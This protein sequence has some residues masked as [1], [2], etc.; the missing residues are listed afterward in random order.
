MP[1]TLIAPF[2]SVAT[3][4]LALATLLAPG[5]AAAQAASSGHVR[6]LDEVP[7]TL[8]SPEARATWARE[9]QGRTPP[10]LLGESQR[11]GLTPEQIRSALVPAS[12][13]GHLALA[14]AR[15]WPQQ[16]GKLVAIACVKDAAPR[17]DHGPDC[18]DLAGEGLRIYLGVLE[19][20]GDGAPRTI[21]RLGPLASGAVGTLPP[22]AWNGRAGTD[23]P[24]VMEADDGTAPATTDVA[25][26]IWERFD[27]A[28][29]RLGEGAP[30]FGLRG[31]WS[32]GYAGGGA[33][34]TALYLFELRDGALRAV[35]GAP[36]SMFKNLA[37]EWNDDGTRQHD[38]SE[39]ANIV[40]VREQ[41]HGGYPD[42]LVRGRD[43]GAGDTYRWSP[44]ARRYQL[45]R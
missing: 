23:M 6:S 35:F 18:R 42:L 32:E 9:M 29:Y 2:A 12:D 14:G 24:I 36:I 45:Q 8:R 19:A 25:P 21:A 44:Q 11:A 16:P 33:T 22:L 34:F 41:S 7:G 1:R 31:G 27:L 10:D 13:A 28:A 5:E 3:A 26:A 4:L 38:I 37:G 40:Q 15:R 39:A 17:F 30:A 43:G 20:T